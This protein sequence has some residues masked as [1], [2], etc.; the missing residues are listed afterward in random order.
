[1]LSALKQYMPEEI[2][3]T[4]PEGGLFLFLTLPEWMDS[5]NCLLKQQIE[6]CRFG[7]FVPGSPFLSADGKW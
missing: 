7:L 4:K 1:M 5:E 6:K 2:K 3:W